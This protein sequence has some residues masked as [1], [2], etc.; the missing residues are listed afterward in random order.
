MAMTTTPKPRVDWRLA[1]MCGAVLTVLFTAQGFVNPQDPSH[2][3]ALGFVFVRQIIRWG[4]WLVLTPAI[5]ATARRYPFGESTRTRWVLGQLLI[6]GVFSALHAIIGSAI[7]IGIGVNVFDNLIDASFAA[8]YLNIGASYIV[9]GMIAAAYQAVAYQRASR[10]RDLE[11]ARLQTDLAEA[12]VSTLE[13]RLRPHFL[14]NTLN[15]IAALVREDP[16][17]AETMIGQLSDLLRA[18]LRTD[19]RTEIR[20]EDEL[21]LVR[22]YLAIQQVR[23]QDRLVVSVDVA[24]GARSAFVPQ[25]ILQPLV[26][27]AV[28]HGIA[29]RES[30]GTVWVHADQPNG[31]LRLT[32]EDDGVGIGNASP[33]LAGSGI[34]LGGLK[35]RLAHLYGANQRVDVLERKPS[36]TRVVIEIPYHREPNAD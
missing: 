31:R 17:A 6:G 28:R 36:G 22:Q 23:F 33:A 2:A 21:H 29:P 14:F 24:D 34:G 12:K 26:E 3:P 32:V 18:S 15:V 7:R 30:G 25:L 16:A 5:I 13:S 4:V 11:A 19:V 9:Y 20:L 27:N 35:S 10:E 1:V 8:F